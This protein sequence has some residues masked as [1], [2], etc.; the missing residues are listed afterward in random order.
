MVE[1][2]GTLSDDGRI[3]YPEVVTYKLVAG[4]EKG[5]ELW[6]PPTVLTHP[7]PASAEPPPL[8]SAAAAKERAD[9]EGKP[10]ATY[11]YVEIIHDAVAYQVL[12]A[13]GLLHHRSHTGV[14]HRVVDNRNAPG[15]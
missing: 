4:P 7:D 13:E 3:A 15:V 9:W 5:T 10:R 6:C 12:R 14:E 11:G 1:F 8:S 2:R